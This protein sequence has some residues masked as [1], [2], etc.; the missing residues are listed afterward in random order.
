MIQLL[1]RTMTICALLC[2]QCFGGCFLHSCWLR[3]CG[4]DVQVSCL[5]DASDDFSCPLL[6][7]NGLNVL[8]QFLIPP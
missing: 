1:S 2:N 6:V 4:R 7:M 8:S 5:V 3:C